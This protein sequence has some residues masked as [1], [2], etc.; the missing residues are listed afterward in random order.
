MGD[1]KEI[2]NNEQ[3]PVKKSEWKRFLTYQWVVRNIP[4]F[5]FLAMLAVVYI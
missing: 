5:F 1:E 2:E 4:F 3:V